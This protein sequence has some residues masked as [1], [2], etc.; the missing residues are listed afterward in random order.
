M[1][2]DTCM[3]NGV[4]ALATAIFTA[5]IG[6]KLVLKR[7]HQRN[8]ITYRTALLLWGHIYSLNGKSEIIEHF[9]INIINNPDNFRKFVDDYKITDVLD[10]ISFLKKNDSADGFSKWFDTNFK[11]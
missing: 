11:W 6:H 3:L 9:C 10:F 1:G 8:W 2:L 5:Y 4:L 7:E